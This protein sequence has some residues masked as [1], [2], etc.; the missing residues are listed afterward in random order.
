MSSDLLYA[1]RTNLPKMLSH[2]AGCV[3]IYSV[4]CILT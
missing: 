1:T 4:Y 3:V 2:V